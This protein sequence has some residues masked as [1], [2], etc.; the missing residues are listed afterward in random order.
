MDTYIAKDQYGNT[1]YVSAYTES[2]AR[3]KAEELLGL[4][5]VISFEKV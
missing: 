4:G 1:V 5:N 2:D 3:Q